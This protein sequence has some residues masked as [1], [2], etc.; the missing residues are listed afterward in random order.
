MKR[1]SFLNAF[2]AG[3]VGAAVATKIPLAW[4]PAK[5]K[6]YAA[7]EYLRRLFNNHVTRWGESPAYIA[8]S[9]DLYAAYQSELIANVRLMPVSDA[10]RPSTLVF[11]GVR[12]GIAST[13]VATW[14]AI[15][16]DATRMNV[17]N[18]S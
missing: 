6:T 7:R 1:R 2:C 10:A 3:L 9:A 11:R 17:T 8:A 16:Y 15:A 12:V 5:T 18:V 13:N 14:T 4:I